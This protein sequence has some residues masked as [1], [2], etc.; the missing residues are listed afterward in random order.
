[1]KF[2]LC[3]L[4]TLFSATAMSVQVNEPIQNPYNDAI[5][6]ILRPTRV[7]LTVNYLREQ[8][9]NQSGCNTD[10]FTQATCARAFQSL[11]QALKQN[12]YAIPVNRLI[13]VRQKMERTI[14]VFSTEFHS[15]VLFVYI[16]DEDAS[17]LDHLELRRVAAQ[18]WFEVNLN[19]VI[20]V[21][22]LLDYL[23]EEI[24]EQRPEITQEQIA[25]TIGNSIVETMFF[26]H[27]RLV[28][29]QS[30]TQIDNELT[31]RPKVFGFQ[32]NMIDEGIKVL[33]VSQGSPAEQAGLFEQDIIVSVNQDSMRGI[34]LDQAGALLG[35]I[36]EATFEVKRDDTL[37]T[38]NIARDYI[39]PSLVS[40]RLVEQGDEKIG[41]VR[42]FTF[43][44]ELAKEQV[45]NA[46]EELEE[47]GM[48]SIVLDLRNNGGGLLHECVDIADLFLPRNKVV[49]KIHDLESLNSPNDVLRTSR[50]AKYNQPLTILINHRSASASELLAGALADHRRAVLVGERSFGKGTVQRYGP[51][52]FENYVLA[53]TIS[54]F[55]QPNGMSN[56]LYGVFPH[57]SVESSLEEDEVQIREVDI[58]QLPIPAT[59]QY[60]TYTV[61]DELENCIEDENQFSDLLNNAPN[62]RGS[63]DLQLLEAF[64]VASCTT[65]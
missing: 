40:Y 11:A 46:L 8:N 3:V 61:G 53:R 34:E 14:S 6:E 29:Q 56:Q 26:D 42:L 50:P 65:N 62:F 2:T 4:L 10:A 35:A 55:H 57:V 15:G 33:G 38:L 31:Q 13:E 45:D 51:S 32:F 41:Y 54:R 30:Y 5:R 58:A 39:T 20:S 24:A 21:D 48:T 22:R 27:S 43:S 12:V 60:V 16:N 28:P 37:L 25:F 19:S 17:Q 23:L 64:D 7:E 44:S 9:F 1:M 18:E 52:I 47:Q 36:E 49:T 63:F 59:D